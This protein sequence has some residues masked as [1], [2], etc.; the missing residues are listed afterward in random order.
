MSYLGWYDFFIISNKGTIVYSVT[1][2]SDLRQ[3]IP[4]DLAESSF[5]QA[6]TLAK[7]SDSTDIHFADFL[8]Y[9]PSNDDPAAFFIKPVIS[10]GK[11]IGYIAYQ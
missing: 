11:R 5:N 2:E 4:T 3:K 10:K 6:F 8:P 9:A 7:Q 1:R